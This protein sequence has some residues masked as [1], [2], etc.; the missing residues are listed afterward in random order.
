MAALK[1]LE[2]K[3]PKAVDKVFVDVFRF[4]R[5]GLPATKLKQWCESL[6]LETAAAESLRPQVASLIEQSLY[7]RMGK[8]EIA[9]LLPDDLSRDLKVLIV[10][11]LVHHQVRSSLFG[12][13]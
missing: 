9:K 3:S 4:R 12:H 6:A 11:I 7:S 5:E 2:E 8:Q 1:H 10:K 13:K